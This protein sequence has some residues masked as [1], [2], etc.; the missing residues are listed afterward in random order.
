MEI[1]LKNVEAEPN[2]LRFHTLR[3]R[4]DSARIRPALYWHGIPDRFDHSYHL[5]PLRC[6]R[7]GL[8]NA[9]AVDGLA[10]GIDAPQH[11]AVRPVFCFMQGNI[12]DVSQEVILA[13]QQRIISR[14]REA[15]IQPV[16]QS[17]LLVHNNAALNARI[18]NLNTVL[19]VCGTGDRLARSEPRTD[20][21]QRT[22]SPIHD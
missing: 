18:W 14:L 12:K 22:E 5:V 15:G 6:I 4:G 11:D 10:A 2:R 1:F 20:G 7:N 9:A 17:V 8:R 19:T 16:V 21:Q 13:N 3:R